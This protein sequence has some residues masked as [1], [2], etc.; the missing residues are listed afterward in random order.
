MSTG[1]LTFV[2]STAAIAQAIGTALQMFQGEWFL[3]L[4]AGVPY[5]QNVLIKNP[6]AGVLALVFQNALL[7][8]LGVT[9]VTSLTLDYDPAARTLAVTW[10]VMTDDGLLGPITTTLGA[11][12]GT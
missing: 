6:N 1:N 2:S 3:D 10:A 7:G 8:V 4:D 11:G 5:F 12:V 9:A